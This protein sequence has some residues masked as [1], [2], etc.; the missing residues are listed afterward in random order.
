MKKF[1]A[2]ITFIILSF[3]HS[4]YA[5][6]AKKKAPDL[7]KIQHIVVIILENHS[8]DNLFGNFPG[9]NGFSNI[10]DAYKQIDETGKE[11]EFLPPVINTRLNPPA[12]DERFPSSLENLPFS[13]DKYLIDKEVTGDLVHKFYQE[14]LQ[15]NDGKMNRFAQISD[16]GALVMG[17]YDISKTG[18][19]QYAKQYS[20]ADNFFHGAFGGS[21]LNHFWLICACSPKYENAPEEL[22]IKL[23]DQGE[24]VKDGQ[25]TEDG[26][27]VNTLYSTYTPHP[28]NA[29]EKGL[30]IPPQNMVTIGDILSEK[31][32]SWAWYA[33]GWNDAISGKPHEL[34]QFH[35]QPFAYFKNFADGTKARKEHLKDEIDFIKAIKKGKLPAVAFYKPLGEFNLHPNYANINSG[36]K[37]ITKILNMIEKTRQWKNTL[38]IVTFDENG[39]FWD[40]VA[41]PKID[42]FGPGARVPTI[43]IS[44]LAKKYFVDHTRYDTTSILKLIETRFNL[45]SLTARDRKANNLTNSLIGGK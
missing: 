42:R 15:I 33:G 41:P 37:H 38:V 45:K 32:I 8:F 30:I 40:H 18:L 3:P 44:P 24:I 10:D 1:I 29:G 9:A 14:Q 39:G 6:H 25:V 27:A 31:N 43:I 13:I 5:R 11:Y 2:L 34:F 17:Y 26:Y 12:I 20:L 4:S 7:K 22:I 28:K 35:H 16:A 23:D 19:W 36:D 21:F